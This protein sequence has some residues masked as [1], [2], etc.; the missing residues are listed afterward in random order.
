[1][2][3]DLGI[4]ASTDTAARLRSH[5]ASCLP[6]AVSIRRIAASQT[7]RP[8]CSYSTSMFPFWQSRRPHSFHRRSRMFSIDQHSKSHFVAMAY[9][10]AAQHCMQTAC[11][12][13]RDIGLLSQAQSYTRGYNERSFP[14]LR[15][16]PSLQSRLSIISSLYRTYTSQT[17]NA[18]QSRN[19]FLL[20]RFVC[21][22]LV[23]LPKLTVLMH[24]Q[25][26]SATTSFAATP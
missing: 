4:N 23:C 8:H 1:L 11:Q 10:I 14:L 6:M 22:L 13:C 12:S 24:C 16:Y 5:E 21:T 7:P 20:F 18:Y 2:S 9:R 19:T 15:V 3:F 26:V 25:K 17:V